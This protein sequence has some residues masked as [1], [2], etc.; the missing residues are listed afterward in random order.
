[1]STPIK[2]LGKYELYEELGRG[3][4]GAVFRANDA[5]LNLERAVK[6]LHPALSTTPE[7]IDRFRRE[8]RVASRLDHPYIVPVYEFG[9][10]DDY[11]LL[12]MKY[13]PM[14]SLKDVLSRE[15]HLDY[16]RCLLILRQ[17]AS[18][19][20]YAYAR[21]EKLIHLDIKPGNILFETSSRPN[22]LENARLADFGFAKALVNNSAVGN[23]SNILLTPSYIPPETWRHNKHTASSDVYSLG[24]VF[25][26]MITGKV[27]FDGESPANIMTKHILDG[28]IFP[29]EWPTEVPPGFDQVLAQA[30][31][32]D[33][34][35][36]FQTAGEF[37]AAMKS[38][39]NQESTGDSSYAQFVASLREQ[40]PQ[41]P[42]V[43]MREHIRELESDE[44]QDQNQPE[45]DVNTEQ[46]I[47][48]EFPT[49]PP[50]NNT[51]Q[52][53]NE[54]DSHIQN[55]T[56]KDKKKN[57]G[58]IF[59]SIGLGVIVLATIL[60]SLINLGLLNINLF[61][62]SNAPTLAPIVIIVTSVSTRVPEPTV[63][64]AAVYIYGVFG[65]T[66]SYTVGDII[67]P[68]KEILTG[69]FGLSLS[70]PANQDG[71]NNLDALYWFPG[72]NGTVTVENYHMKPTLKSGA[73][74]LQSTNGKSDVIFTQ[75][76]I[77][78]SVNQ[79]QLIVQM[80]G[81]EIIINCIKGD[82]Q[83]QIGTDKSKF[84]KAGN[85]ITYIPTTR[86]LTINSPITTEELF[87]WDNKCNGCL[88]LMPSAT[89]TVT[90]TMTPVKKITIVPA[91][92]VVPAKKP[93]KPNSGGTSPTKDPNE[94]PKP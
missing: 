12:A 67:Q 2:I 50:D 37:A 54:M 28:P 89:T 45:A 74:Y 11:Y 94:R 8:A 75:P 39:T 13:M 52:S 55:L 34:E 35:Q 70:L 59:T 85:F 33:P 25:F 5:N 27:L 87:N 22:T 77:T 57:N 40:S 29:Q 90:P 88:G 63:S 72:S 86:P 4:F 26:E 10:F 53:R 76:G 31:T 43:D 62:P 51:N 49:P 58:L 7:F 48:T 60:T 46:D 24:C 6:V 42:G 91:S 1:M 80:I 73:I 79:G 69:D 23:S 32:Q 78:V 20:D 41:R 44:T 15:G 61:Q 84:I 56:K 14:G 82:C 3:S 81:P 64:Q 38:L 65:S 17:I 18:A 68:E 36:R 66:N 9:Q 93:K 92:T 30:L 21:P 16:P 83:L 71:G 47:E 19:L